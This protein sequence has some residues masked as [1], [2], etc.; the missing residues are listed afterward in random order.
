[1]FY[2]FV[3]AGVLPF[4]LAGCPGE[5]PPIHTQETYHEV[6]VTVDGL[7]TAFRPV[8]L[9]S[10]PPTNP[11]TYFHHTDKPELNCYDLAVDP[12]GVNRFVSFVG[13][14][15]DDTWR[16]RIYTGLGASI[17]S[18]NPDILDIPDPDIFSSCVPSRIEHLTGDLF[19]IIWADNDGI[20]SA[21]LDTSKNPP[22]NLTLG[23]TFEHDDFE[24]DENSD[25]LSVRNASMALFKDEL[26][27]V[28]APR[29]KDQ[30]QMVRGQISDDGIQLNS[31]SSFFNH[32]YDAI[33]DVLATETEFFVA[34]SDAEGIT[35]WERST[36]PNWQVYEQCENNTLSPGKLL[37][38]NPEGDFL[39]LTTAGL[40]NMTSCQTSSFVLPVISG[41]IS[42]HPGI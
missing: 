40:I 16:L 15:D 28:W 1:M 6:V 23:D 12:N 42:Y 31:S 26:R 30:I 38:R 13:E 17:W 39:T 19:G 35:L 24:F 34:T 32:S 29:E 27:I 3:L 21:L 20:N 25:R 2:R 33:S 41:V 18:E 4:M 37:Y 22:F 8:D 10:D 36:S 11:W 5:P 7:R 14:E 9:P